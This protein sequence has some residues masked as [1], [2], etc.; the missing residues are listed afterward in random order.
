MHKYLVVIFASIL[1]GFSLAGAA[2]AQN[3]DWGAQKK[4]LKAQQKLEWHNLMLQQRNMKRS[5]KGQS[6]SSAQRAQ[7]KHEMQRQRRDLK[8]RQKDA[9]QDLQDRQRNAV[10]MQRSYGN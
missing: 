5:W 6:V 3:V 8:I 4:M 9:R 1:L 10:S 7:A 2:K